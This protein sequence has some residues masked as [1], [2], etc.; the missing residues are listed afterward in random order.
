MCYWTVVLKL[1]LVQLLLSRQS[2]LNTAAASTPSLHSNKCDGLRWG[3]TGLQKALCHV[4]VCTEPLN[5]LICDFSW[6]SCI[7]FHCLS[8][9]WSKTY[10]Y[11]RSHLHCCFTQGCF[12]PE[13]LI[14]FRR[15]CEKFG[16]N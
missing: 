10:P 16:C 9:T 7:V 4:F 12:G 15:K 14:T 1:T 8:I 13:A 2:C 11:Q 3:S 5:A 6:T